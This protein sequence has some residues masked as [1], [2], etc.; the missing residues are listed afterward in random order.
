M[1]AARL[2]L[3]CENRM[4]ST[5]EQ[6]VVRTGP[7]DGL[8]AYKNGRSGAK[9]Y[10][11]GADKS[12]AVA[13]GAVDRDLSALHVSAPRSAGHVCSTYGQTSPFPEPN[14]RSEQQPRAERNE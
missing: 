7:K 10:L 3:R 12:R 5:T 8:F 11:R 14:A 13:A 1:R 4:T 2:S 6:M 9:R